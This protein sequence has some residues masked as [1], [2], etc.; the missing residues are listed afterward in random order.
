M[1]F[2]VKL[3]LAI[4]FCKLFVM[5]A[6]KR[7]KSRKMIFA[8]LHIAKNDICNAAH[9]YLQMN[10]LLEIVGNLY[11]LLNS[12]ICFPC[13]VTLF[14]CSCQN[15]FNNYTKGFLLISLRRKGLVT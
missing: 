5:T 12:R 10:K 15:K 1:L 9:K 14:F 13:S 6:E 4:I 3:V 7:N 2:I 11:S 8:M